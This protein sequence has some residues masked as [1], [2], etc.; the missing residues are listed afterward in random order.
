MIFLM[1][2]SLDFTIKFIV[3]LLGMFEILILYSNSLI[4]YVINIALLN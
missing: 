3:K 2:I 4:E 1:G